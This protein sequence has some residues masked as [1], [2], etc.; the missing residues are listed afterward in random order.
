MFLLKSHVVLDSYEIVFANIQSNI[1]SG[2]FLLKVSKKN[3]FDESL[4]IKG[5]W[6]ILE[7][8]AWQ[9]RRAAGWRYRY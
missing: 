6:H 3:L 7:K 5:G 8:K 4:T 9:F 2:I 1:D